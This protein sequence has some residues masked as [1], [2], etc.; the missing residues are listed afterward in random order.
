MGSDG[1]LNP[2]ASSSA[3]MR[4]LQRTPIG[5]HICMLSA[6]C[7]DYALRVVKNLPIPTNNSVRRLYHMGASLRLLNEILTSTDPVEMD[8]VI[9]AAL[10]LA[11]CGVDELGLDKYRYPKSPFASPLKDAQWISVYGRIRVEPQ[12]AAGMLFLIKRRGGLA[13]VEL[14]GLAEILS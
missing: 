9:L 11:F 13:K 14:P 3:W 4:F 5:F 2:L 1:Q 6:L 7:H 10:G 12:H 8:E